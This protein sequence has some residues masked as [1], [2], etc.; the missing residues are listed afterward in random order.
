MERG[1]NGGGSNDCFEVPITQ[2]KTNGA[3]GPPVLG[4]LARSGPSGVLVV[5]LLAAGG[6]G[7]ALGRGCRAG[8]GVRVAW[9]GPAGVAWSAGGAGWEDVGPLVGLRVFFFFFFSFL[10]SKYIFK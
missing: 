2:R 1:G 9:R 8:R 10:I 7:A 3:A 6:A 4:F 5:V